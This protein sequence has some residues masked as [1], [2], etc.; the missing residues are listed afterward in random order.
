MSAADLRADMYV[1]EAL[2][3]L[4]QGR[5]AEATTAARR[6][7][8]LDRKS[9]LGHLLMG[10]ALRLCGRARAARRALERARQLSEENGEE[11]AAAIEAEMLL[12][13]QSTSE[14]AP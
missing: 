6:A 10:R 9:R 1:K 5:A 4:D 3:L 8:F 7:V 14:V 12:L 13:E 11:I 2:A